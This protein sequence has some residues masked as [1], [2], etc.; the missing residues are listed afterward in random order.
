MLPQIELKDI[1]FN[2][3]WAAG[4]GALLSRLHPLIFRGRENQG[5]AFGHAKKAHSSHC[6]PRVRCCRCCCGIVNISQGLCV[7]FGLDG[8]AVGRGFPYRDVDNLP[9]NP[10]NCNG[11]VQPDLVNMGQRSTMGRRGHH[12]AP[13][14]FAVEDAPHASTDRLRVPLPVYRVVP[15]L[16]QFRPP[17]AGPSFARPPSPMRNC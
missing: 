3:I 8:I 1:S 16:L 2:S 13:V 10:E 11:I 15:F 4:P 5:L 6:T 14:M 12:N 17:W 7:R 9:D